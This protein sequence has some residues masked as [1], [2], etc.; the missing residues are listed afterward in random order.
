MTTSTTERVRRDKPT[1]YVDRVKTGKDGRPTFT[2]SCGLQITGYLT[3]RGV[4]D[5]YASHVNAKLNDAI[6]AVLALCD[7]N[8]DEAEGD[9]VRISAIRAAINHALKEPEHD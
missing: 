3:R 4:I 9:A 8:D 7:A 2:C 1:H 5:M 6:Q